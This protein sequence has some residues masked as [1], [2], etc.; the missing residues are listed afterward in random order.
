MCLGYSVVFVANLHVCLWLVFGTWLL[1]KRKSWTDLS[2]QKRPRKCQNH[3]VGQMENGAPAST[4]SCWKCL[5]RGPCMTSCL[6]QL[7]CVFGATS[8]LP[9]CHTFS[10]SW[11]TRRGLFQKLV[12]YFIFLCLKRSLSVFKIGSRWLSFFLFVFFSDDLLCC[13]NLSLIPAKRRLLLGSLEKGWHLGCL[14]RASPQPHAL[15]LFLFVWSANYFLIILL[16]ILLNPTFG[17]WTSW[18]NKGTGKQS[19]MQCL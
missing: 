18:L 7:I 16:I 19:C 12:Y 3:W 11:S 10:S 2:N 4:V 9:Q 13:D 6:S 14:S 5:F 1:Q 17:C 8:R 15:A